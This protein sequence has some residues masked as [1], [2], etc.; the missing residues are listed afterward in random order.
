MNARAQT[1]R[2]LKIFWTT[3]EVNEVVAK[4]AELIMAGNPPLYSGEIAYGQVVLQAQSFLPVERRRP[5]NSIS[6]NTTI[7]K[8]LIAT[9]IDR[10]T[11]ANKRAVQ[12]AHAAEEAAADVAAITQDTESAPPIR[13][14]SLTELHTQLVSSIEQ[15]GQV[16]KDLFIATMLKAASE[17]FNEVNDSIKSVTATLPKGPITI[18]AHQE[19]SAFGTVP[20]G[21]V[22]VKAHREKII[23]LGGNEK[24]AEHV[25][26]ENGLD[27]VYKIS[28]EDDSSVDK[29]ALAGADHI[30][31]RV[32]FCSHS[33]VTALLS[34]V[35][36]DKVKFIE[37]TSAQKVNDHLLERFASI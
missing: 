25:V 10:V 9:E 30:V 20:R 3:R 13:S 4:A 6:S 19:V 26:I 1:P 15:M 23:I 32:R 34:T 24:G 8:R 37:S 22:E 18:H 14:L 21:A 28:Y 5:H 2:P 11:E 36:K 35:P 31:V 27:D 16:Y 17:G 29:A 33:K 7:F 12:E